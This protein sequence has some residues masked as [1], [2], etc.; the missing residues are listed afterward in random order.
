MIEGSESRRS[1]Y[2]LTWRLL[3]IVLAIGALTTSL[4]TRTFHLT[5][6]QNVSVQADS[7]QAIRQHLDGDAAQWVPPVPLVSSLQVPVFYPYVA[8]AGPPLPVLLFDK[9]LYNRPPPSC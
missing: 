8:P 2:W 9:S 3:P 4:A 7:S 1:N 5:L 6:S